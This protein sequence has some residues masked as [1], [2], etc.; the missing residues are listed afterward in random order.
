MTEDQDREF[1]IEVLRVQ[2]GYRRR[3]ALSTAYLA[4]GVS[5]YI[6]AGGIL[7]QL[8]MKEGILVWT[9][10]TALFLSLL[11]VGT[12]L[13]SIGV[14]ILTHLRN[15]EEEEIQNLRNRFLQ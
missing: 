11:F 15:V 9:L 10:N 4:W 3:I 12:A 13:M 7:W 5:I 14:W 1:A 6:F 8:I 2:L